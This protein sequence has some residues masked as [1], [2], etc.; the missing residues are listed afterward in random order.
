MIESEII[1]FEFKRVPVEGPRDQLEGL[2]RSIA[3][4]NDVHL[5]MIEKALGNNSHR[6]GEIYDRG[7]GSPALNE[8]GIVEHYGE[9]PHGT[10]ESSGAYRLLSDQSMGQRNGF[11][12]YAGFDSSCAHAGD[13]ITG[14]LNRLFRIGTDTQTCFEAAPLGHRVRHSTHELQAFGVGIP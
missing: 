3:D 8:L 7:L 13:Y 6:I 2:K 10:R 11:I 9:V 1:E 5:G 14:I 12:L 4:A